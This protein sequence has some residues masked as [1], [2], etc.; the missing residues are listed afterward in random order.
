[1]AR[2]TKTAAAKAKGKEKKPKAPLKT[3]ASGGAT[4]RKPVSK[5]SQKSIAAREAGKATKASRNSSS[6]SASAARKTSA[7]RSASTTR[8]S[9]AAKQLH[10]ISDFTGNL[11]NHLVGS[12]MSQFSETAAQRV[13][14]RFCD[15][16]EKLSEA[17]KDLRA[18]RDIVLH[19]VIGTEAKQ[20]IEATAAQKKVPCFDLTGSLTSFLATTLGEQPKNDMDRVH[21]ID[22]Q[23]FHRIDA[24]EFTLQ[25][26]D[27]RRLES[28]HEAD[29]VLVGLSRVSKS[30]TSTFL[31]SLGYKTANVSFAPELGLPKELKACAGRV[32][33]LT[34]Q[35]KRLFEIR[36]RRFKLNRFATAF[37]KRNE[38]INYLDLRD[39]TREVMAAEE[40]YRQAGYKVVDVTQMTIEE[41]ATH[42]LDVLGKLSV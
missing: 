16:P 7:R 17:L 22:E 12:V 39:V 26:D 10:L 6:T 30:P 19:A 33:G 4:K 24:M 32:V 35:P 31:G 42:V 20:R 9:S 5:T 29:I 34:M 2:E 37:E 36:Q 41:A 21:Q 38:S 18:P 15:S 25:H 1:M 23:Y 28:I 11:A 13:M 8:V 27:S 3:V 14:H 40:M